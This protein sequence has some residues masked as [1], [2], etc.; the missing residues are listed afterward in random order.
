MKCSEENFPDLFHAI[1]W[2][3]GTLGFLVSV[4]IRIIPCKSHVA[5]TYVPYTAK[6]D[7]LR[8]FEEESKQETFDFVECLAYSTNE[9][10]VMLGNM[11]DISDAKANTYNAIGRWY[12]EWFYL[13]VKKFLSSD[14]PQTEIIPIRDYFHR[15]SKSLFW[16]IQDIV[17]FGNNV[18]FRYALGWAMPPKPSLMKLTQTEALRQL[19]ELHH[20]VQDMLVPIETLSDTLDVFDKEVNIYPLWLCPFKIPHTSKGFV[21]S[22]NKAT[23]TGAMYVD[24][25]AYGNPTTPAYVAKDTCRRIEEY[26]RSVNGY[27]MMYADSYMTRYVAFSYICLFQSIMML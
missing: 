19:Y 4:E 6:S 14:K 12:K 13:H 10:V 23:G 24:I 18:F 22:D 2:S 1:P 15:H 5:L 17:P 16:E 8:R 26:V 11:T 25:G 21:H 27:Q 9:Y 20:V 3:H 7:A